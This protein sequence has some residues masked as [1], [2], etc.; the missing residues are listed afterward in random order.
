MRGLPCTVLLAL[1]AALAAACDE[2]G[3]GVD[4]GSE[5]DGAI[6][7]ADEGDVTPEPAS[8]PAVD[9]GPEPASDPVSDPAADP[10]TEPTT[11]PGTDGTSAGCVTHD[12]PGCGGCACEACVCEIEPHCC[13]LAWDDACVWDC[14]FICGVEC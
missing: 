6:D 13:S 11:D 2:D 8:D 7:P 10:A 12:T 4:A 14:E 9:P 5:Q 1:V 3:G